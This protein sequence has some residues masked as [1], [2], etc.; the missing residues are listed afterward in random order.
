MSIVS[1]VRNPVT[2]ESKIAEMVRSVL[3]PLGGLAGFVS[4][5]DSVMLKPNLVTN[6]KYFT[7]A[8]TDPLIVQALIRELKAIGVNDVIVADSSWTGCPTER[9]FTATGLKGI[10]DREGVRLLDLKKDAFVDVEV[11]A[12]NELGGSVQIAKTVLEVD[13][14]INLPKLKAHCQTMVTLSLKNLKGCIHD[15]EKQRFH[16]LNLHNAVAELNTVLKPDLIVLDGIIGEMTAELGCDPVRLDTVVAGTDPVALDSVC[17]TMLGYDPHEIDHIV[18]AGELGV[19]VGPDLD[20]IDIIGGVELAEIRGAAG[21]SIGYD[22]YAEAFNN[23]GIKIIEEGACSSC[24]AGLFIALKRMEDE[25]ELDKLKGSTIFIGQNIA[26]TYADI[27]SDIDAANKNKIGI[28]KCSGKLEGLD[29]KIPGCPPDA[30]K[31]CRK[32]VE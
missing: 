16:R 14:L 1:I 29:L 30:L 4:T 23:Y 9:T 15:R 27:V 2:D 7:G 6:R 12:G 28:G 13:K 24:S 31:I 3:E 26:S 20:L 18:R 25:G 19:G 11:K 32:I 21:E 10:C 22:R 5:D 8:T 17:T